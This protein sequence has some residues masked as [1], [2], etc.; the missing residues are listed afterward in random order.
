WWLGSPATQGLQLCLERAD[1]DVLV[2][3]LRA[4]LQSLQKVFPGADPTGRPGEEQELLRVLA[5]QKAT[6][7]VEVR[8]TRDP[9]DAF[10][11]GRPGSREDHLSYERR[12]H[13]HDLLRDH[14]AHREAEQ[15]HLFKTHRLNEG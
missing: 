12:L 7:H 15:V 11:P 3:V 5:R 1:G 8:D 14:P 9:A 6:G 10:A 13:Q 2:T 4:L